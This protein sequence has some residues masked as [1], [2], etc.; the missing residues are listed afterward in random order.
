MLYEAIAQA[1]KAYRLDEEELLFSWLLLCIT[2]D[3]VK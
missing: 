1:I 3:L 2:H